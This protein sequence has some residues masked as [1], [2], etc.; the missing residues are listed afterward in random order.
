M[1]T[2]RDSRD[3]PAS[4][5]IPTLVASREITND[6]VFIK[7]VSRLSELIGYPRRGEAKARRERAA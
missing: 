2:T 1:T 3:P 7:P 6:C 4:A 5:G